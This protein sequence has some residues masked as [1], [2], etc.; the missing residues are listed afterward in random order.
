[1][2]LYR[3]MFLF[4]FLL[5]GLLFVAASIIKLQSTRA[6]LEE[7]LSSH[8]QDTATS[9]GLSILPY[10]GEGDLATVE[11]MLNAVFDRGYYR[12]IVLSD[13]DGKT[14]LERRQEI[15][16]DSVP[17]WFV[18]AIPLATPEASTLI[19]SGW[20]RFGNLRVT[21][22]PG[23]AY[24]TLWQS[25]VNITAVF[26]AI[27]ALTL[28]AGA[29]GLKL[30]LKPLR[31]VEK[32][33]EDL[34]RRQYRLQATLPRTRELRR[35]VVAMN[36]MTEKVR[37]M[38]AEQAQLAE[39]FRQSAYSD[40][41]TGIGNRRY[42][43]GQT[44]AAMEGETEE[45]H[46]ALLLVA[47]HDLLELNRQ[48][49]YQ[50][51]D[52][53]LQEI[54]K[55]LG[56]AIKHLP[57][58][59]LARI[60]GGTFAALL[61]EVSEEEA[62]RL[63]E[64][65]MRRLSSAPPEQLAAHRDLAYLGGVVY[66][67]ATPLGELLAEADRMLAMAARQGANGWA[68][69]PRSPASQHLPR[70]EQQWREKLDQVLRS[71]SIS[72]FGQKTVGALDRNRV[73]HCEI[74][75]RMVMDNG[76]LLSAG[77]FIPLAERLRRISAIDRQVLERGLALTT[78]EIDSEALAINLST[79]SLK[80]GEFRG[81]L[82]DRLGQRPRQAPTVI[83]EFTEFQATQELSLLQDFANNLRKLGHFIGLDHF[84]QSFVDFGYLKTLQPKHVKIDRA[85]TDELKSDQGNSRFFIGALAS[86][87]HS[88]D[89]LVIAEGVEDQRQQAILEELKIDGIQGYLV[90][91]PKEITHT[92]AAA[93]GNTE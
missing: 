83:F 77:L 4:I 30:L 68:I 34:C 59:A 17:S 32:Q 64:D 18:S 11:T 15:V 7:Q 28:L 9:L 76:Q 60:S 26:A 52:Q 78:Q 90:D 3:Q 84:G 10:I 36:T 85:F 86:V 5:C 38:F 92:A 13:L 27:A 61:P 14:L 81:W 41:L 24:Q 31:E 80:D 53:L 20:Q 43:E 19:T 58:A 46:G 66:N 48:K 55:N 88:L 12:G 69:A 54:A 1:M 56:E 67:Q 73:L 49:G 45:V 47:V 65:T 89:I 57:R 25:S 22:H 39:N 79:A 33:A 62:R 71:K 16:I 50:Y 91:R 51:S 23:L 87:A 74:L 8:A 37:L 63:A 44:A 2:T 42:L 40:T 82:L 72:I 35:V 21:S 70:G 29:W 93:G 75:A 6:F